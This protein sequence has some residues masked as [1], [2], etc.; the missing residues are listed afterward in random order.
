MHGQFFVIVVLVPV[1]LNRKKSYDCIIITRHDDSFYQGDDILKLQVT[2]QHDF[3]IAR[4]LKDANPTK[5]KCLLFKL[6][7]K[8]RYLI[9]IP[10][11]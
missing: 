5:P 9:H 3:D 2:L 1:Q 7:V 4:M 6:S 11:I 10:N 8:M